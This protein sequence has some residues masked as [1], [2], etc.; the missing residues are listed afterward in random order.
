MTRQGI[1]TQLVHLDRTSNHIEQGAVHSP[2]TNSVLYEYKDAQAIIDVFQGKKPGHVY[3]RSSSP[4]VSALQE[5][6]NKLEDGVGALCFATGMGAI[7]STLLALLKQGD[8]L[9]VSRYLFGN[10]RS[11]MGSL[12]SFGIQ[13]SY[14]DVTKLTEVIDA[15]QP[16]TRGVY[17]E[18]IANP[19]TQVADVQS[20]GSYC[21]ERD[22]LFILDNTM[23]P[24][25]IFDAKAMQASLV[26]SSLTKYISGHGNVLGGAVVDTGNFLWQHYPNIQQQYKNGDPSQWGLT[27]IKKKGLRDMGATLAPGCAHAISIGMETLALRMQKACDNA[28]KLA[29]FLDSHEKIQDVFYPGL[30]NHPQHFIA[31]EH[32]QE[33]YGAILS[34]NLHESIDVV[35]FLNSLKLVICATHLGDNRTLALPVAATIYSENTP[36]EREQM[37]IADS[38]IRLS[39]GIEDIDDLV[40]DFTQALNN[41]N[42]ST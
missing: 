16:N 31:R 37:G 42:L 5:M 2:T 32:F 36:Q 18:T 30:S 13:I 6:I 41:F 33:G 34:I 3:S 20:I 29:T 4:S 8:H 26:L 35:A 22:I 23:T 12:E 17:C 15:Y 21:K 19:V 28:L 25:A 10:T 38:M 7:S 9:I 39:V 14:V 40:T 27:Q 11:L 24:S 1:T